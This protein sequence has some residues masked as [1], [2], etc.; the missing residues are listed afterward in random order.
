MSFEIP[1]PLLF[2]APKRTIVVV[3]WVNHFFVRQVVDMEH[4]ARLAHAE[5]PLQLIFKWA[6]CGEEHYEHL[7]ALVLHAIAGNNLWFITFI[8][9]NLIKPFNVAKRKDKDK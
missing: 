5:Q 3:I 8:G 9:N 6:L 2:D 1:A 7:L 4:S